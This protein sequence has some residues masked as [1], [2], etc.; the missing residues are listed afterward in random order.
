[1]K[2]KSVKI[3]SLRSAARGCIPAIAFLFLLCVPVSDCAAQ[4]D[5]KNR[6]R[7]SRIQARIFYN[8]TGAFSEDAIGGSVDLWNSPFDA[9]YSTL[10]TVELEGLPKYLKND[11]RVELVARYVPFYR[12]KG[13]IVVRRIELIRNGSESGKSYAAFWLKNT[14]CNPVRLAARIVGRGQKRVVRE[15]INFGCGE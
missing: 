8:D 2:T 9:S 5:E 12:E 1:M 7:I 3:T 10:V 13:G 6:I 4:E 15:T 14:G 11:I